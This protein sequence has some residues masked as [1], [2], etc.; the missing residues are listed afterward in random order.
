MTNFRLLNDEWFEL[1]LVAFS[2]GRTPSQ[3]LRRMVQ[4]YLKATPVDERIR[5]VF[6]LIHAQ[7]RSNRVFIAAAAA[8]AATGT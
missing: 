3:E 5:E 1:R 7:T 8:I 4:D 6:A 2:H